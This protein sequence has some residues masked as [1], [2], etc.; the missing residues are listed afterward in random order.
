ML[1][2]WLVAEKNVPLQDAVRFVVG[3]R[4]AVCPNA[5][6]LMQLGELEVSISI[7]LN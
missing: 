5:K 3:L 1:I 4:P 6:F 7:M 2:A